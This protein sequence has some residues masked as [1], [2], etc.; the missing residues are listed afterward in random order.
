MFIPWTVILEN[1]EILNVCHVSF[2]I[3]T[4]HHVTSALQGTLVCGD[5]SFSFIEFR[6][7]LNDHRRFTL[8]VSSHTIQVWYIFTYIY[9]KNQPFMYQKKKTSPM[10]GM[11]IVMDLFPVAFIWA[12]SGPTVGVGLLRREAWKKN[13]ADGG[14]EA[15]WS[16]VAESGQFNTKTHTQSHVVDNMF[17]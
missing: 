9:H 15:L 6:V 8:H 17:L 3:M 12:P 4:W 1:T 11:G 16:N 2:L 5:V 7:C 14:D 13:G 10:D